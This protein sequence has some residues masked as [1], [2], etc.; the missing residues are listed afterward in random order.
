MSMLTDQQAA[1][2]VQ[3]VELQTAFAYYAYTQIYAW[4]GKKETRDERKIKGM[5]FYVHAMLSHTANISKLLWPRPPR[6]GRSE[7][8]A[9]YERRAAEYEERGK[10]LCVLLHVSG[11]SPLQDRIIR[12]HFEHYDERLQEN[13]ADEEPG[14]IDL[15]LVPSGAISPGQRV[16][17]RCFSA[18]EMR[19]YYRDD[20]KELIDV[21]D[22]IRKVR[23]VIREW[24][25]DGHG[26]DRENADAPYNSEGW[27]H[28]RY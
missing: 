1:R 21:A 3:E 24:M 9:D 18:G 2:F 12:N 23:E 28:G 8:L 22:A 10:E 17:Q 6:R 27:I 15:A 26:W 7:S 11:D 20:L 25:F 19:I 13:D 4:M 5:F 16:Y 14:W